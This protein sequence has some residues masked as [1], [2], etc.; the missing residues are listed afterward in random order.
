MHEYKIDKFGF[1]RR[2]GAI[3]GWTPFDFAWAVRGWFR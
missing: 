2:N 3:V 1:L